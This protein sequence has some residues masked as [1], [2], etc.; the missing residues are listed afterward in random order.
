MAET[1]GSSEFFQV[2]AALNPRTRAERYK[3]V[4]YYVS[5]MGV[6]VSSQLKQ[7]LL[8]LRQVADQMADPALAE[9]ARKSYHESEFLPAVKELLCIWIHLDAA[10]QG[11]ELMPAWLMN[12]LKL[13]LYASDYLIPQP[14]AMSVM[15]LHSDCRDLE[16]L[17]TEAAMKTA[18]Y[19][20]FGAG[21]LAL[22]P[23]IKPI[24]VNSRPHRQQ[25][26]E[27]SLTLPI[28]SLDLKS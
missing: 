12:Y 15:D 4:H 26:L 7:T 20:G 8:G 21:A 6:S 25:H 13:A 19:L 5:R 16:S 14:E 24:L 9:I 28:E 22:T 18:E 2:R 23:A 17:M 10:D 11:G 27:R 1:V 3:R